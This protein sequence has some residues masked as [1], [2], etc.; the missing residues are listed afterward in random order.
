MDHNIL[1]LL[2]P[3]HSSHLIQ[4]LDVGIF[5][6][7]K[8]RMSEELDK[9]LRYGF[10]NIKKFEWANCYRIA[11]PDAMK[12]SNIKSAWS[13]AGL[14]PFNPRKVI[15]CIRATFVDQEIVLI[16]DHESTVNA[17][18]SESSYAEKFSLVPH[19]PSKV[20]SVALRS[21]S[22]ALAHNVQ[23]GI[24]NTSTREYILKESSL[25]T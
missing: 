18:T 1:V 25:V 5:S 21:V 9:I 10:S 8:W 16:N 3:P 7:L 17:S 24:F 11:R 14:I 6:P 2:L 13:G 23:A 4:P 19:T 12:P 22:E 20:N 15:R